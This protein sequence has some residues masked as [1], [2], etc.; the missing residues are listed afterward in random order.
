MCIRDRSQDGRY[1][2]ILSQPQ[3]LYTDPTTLQGRLISEILPR[4]DA[5]RALEVI[6]QTL[7]TRQAQSFEYELETRKL[8]KRNFEVRTA[9]LDGLLLG[10]PAVVLL[11]RDITQ[12]LS[13]IHI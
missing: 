4:E 5:G 9:P 11:A 6:Q 1:L 7:A 2:E 13:L 8:G 12:H 3:L 10:R